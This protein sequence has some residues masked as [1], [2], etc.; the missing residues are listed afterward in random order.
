LSIGF[1]L[2]SLVLGLSLL[3]GAWPTPSAAQSGE[4]PLLALY[5]PWFSP[6]NFG[7]GQTS[8]SPAEPYESDDPLVIARQIEQA[9]QAGIDGF[10]VAWLGPG[11]RTDQNLA[12]ILAQ[13]ARRG[14]KVSVYFETDS[15]GDAEQVAAN[16]SYLLSTYASQPAFL[17]RDGRPA[18]F[19]WRQQ[20]HAP[21][22]WAN[23]RTQVDPERGSVWIAEGTTADYFGAFDG[24]HLF[25]IAWAADPA[26]PLRTWAGRT[27]QAAALQGLRLWVPTIMPGYDDLAVR[28]G[29]ARDRAAGGYYQAT[30]EAALATNPTWAVLITS[31]NQWPEGTQI[32]PSVSYGRLYLD[33]TAAFKARLR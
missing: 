12:R 13:A 5:Y 31:W 20:A 10:V 16:L 7:P 23:I 24:L 11:N 22:T 4:R 32:E 33:L 6:H 30:M 14:F 15:M 25:N 3:L 27:A 9:Q 19:F 8:D 28:G 17:R 29:F 1:V 26:S 18:I 21:A 2:L